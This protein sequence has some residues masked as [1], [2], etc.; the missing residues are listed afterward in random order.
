MDSVWVRDPD[1]G[2]IL[3]NVAE[4][5]ADGAEVVPQDRKNK[6]RVAGF[7]D[8]YQAGDHSKQYEDNCKSN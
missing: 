7:D 5:F 2:F 3:G 4:W 8:I 1:E 6:K